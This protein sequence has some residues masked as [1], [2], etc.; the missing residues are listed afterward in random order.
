ME[1]TMTVPMDEEILK[2][3]A[4]RVVNYL[5]EQ[6]VNEPE[7]MKLE[8]ARQHLFC[9]KS[10]EWIRLY[11]FDRYP[12]TAMNKTNPDGFVVNPRGG[13]GKTT[14][15]NVPLAKK[16]LA[17]HRSEIDWNERLES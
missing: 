17:T 4:K 1:V 3:I 10:P 16:W 8:P 11:I 6:A 2:S 15:I 9:N 13:R 7:W 5:P 14:Q 12:E